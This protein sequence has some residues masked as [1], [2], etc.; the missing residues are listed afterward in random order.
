MIIDSGDLYFWGMQLFYDPNISGVQYELGP[1]ESRHIVQVLRKKVGD[2]LMVTDGKG[3]RYHAEI[4]EAGKRS[5]LL[6]VN[7]REEVLSNSNHIHIAV[8]P[9]KSMDRLEWFVEK[10]VEIGVG[11]ISFIYCNRS[12]RKNLKIQR[13]EKI[14]IAAMKQSGRCVLPKINDAVNLVNWIKA[15]GAENK[16]IAHCVDSENKQLL[17]DQPFEDCEQTC[18]LIGPEGDFTPQEIE[19]TVKYGF[20]P[21]SLGEAR[22]RTETA[23]LAACHIVNLMTS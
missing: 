23:A 2:E 20:Q 3:F 15:V 1:E 10:A 12:E 7:S 22:L 13:V 8:A 11:E 6:K 18:I 17:K 16:F 21:V 9:T 4:V 5:C 19:L 14:L